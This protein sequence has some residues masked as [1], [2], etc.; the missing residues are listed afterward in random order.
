MQLPNCKNCGAPISYSAG[1]SIRKCEYCGTRYMDTNAYENIII[2]GHEFYV[3]KIE[4][5][6]ISSTLYAEDTAVETER[7]YKRKI[8]LIEY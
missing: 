6:C 3:S 7:V 8:T 2:D 5:R 4:T 1:T